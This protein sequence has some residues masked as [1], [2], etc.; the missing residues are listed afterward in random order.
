MEDKK[1]E[2]EGQIE[3]EEFEDEDYN[4][5][6]P[7]I[8]ILLVVFIV[9]FVS[10]LSLFVYY[11]FYQGEGK[12]NFSMK[13]R[14]MDNVALNKEMEQENAQ[15]KIQVDSLQNVINQF[16]QDTNQVVQE[17][18]PKET[19]SNNGGSSSLFYPDLAGE[20]YEVQI[21]AFRNFN[22]AKYDSKLVNMN[23]DKENGMQKLVI[24]R[25]NTFEEA[26]SFKKDILSLG[27]QNAFIVKKIDGKRQKFDK[28]CN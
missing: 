17:A 27:I 1:F 12:W 20:K 26:C 13:K 9:L 28:W 14:G 19:I 11:Q 4:E 15:L 18:P 24:G 7:G 23:V 5:R 22:F 16:G 8:Y 2:I 3:E 6:G 25:F 10:I 21:G